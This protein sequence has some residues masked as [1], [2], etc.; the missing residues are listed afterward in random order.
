MN[1]RRAFFIQGLRLLGAASLALSWPGRLW[2]QGKRRILPGHV[3]GTD[4]AQY[5]P[6]TI[7][8]RNLS[9]TPIE[10]FG[11][12]GQSDLAVDPARWK[13]VVDGAVERPLSLGLEQVKARP[14]L[15]SM[16]LLICPGVFSFN[17]LWKG[18]SLGELLQEA[19]P[20]AQANRVTIRGVG[21]AGA[22][23]EHFSLREVLAEEVF[24]A[25]QVNGRDLP[26]KHGF[27]LR[28][29]AGSHYGDDWVKYV[30]RVSLSASG[31]KG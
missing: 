8:N 30:A 15:E 21:G 18:L 14:V 10:R 3:K 16:V 2:A 20:H 26:R 13:L 29:V 17:A 5:N 4:L 9:L 22:K 27:P 7:D 1:K 23:E 25:Y 31:K 19:K 11:T 28:V 6:A 12:M 24:L